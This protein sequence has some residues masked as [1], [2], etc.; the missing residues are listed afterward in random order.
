MT[1][2]K[3]VVCMGDS[4]TEGYGIAEEQKTYP[5][6]LQQILGKEYLVINKG[7]S[8]CCVTNTQKDGITIGL[9]YVQQEEY[10]EALQERGDIY[11][12]LLGTNDAQDGLDDVEDIQ[13]PYDNIIQY[14]N[15]FEQ[16]FQRILDD[17]Y[18][19]NSAAKIYVGIPAPVMECIW[20]KHQEKYLEELL[21]YYRNIRKKNPE[22]D[23][24]DIHTIFMAL[25]EE[26]CK[27]LYQEDNLHPNEEGAELI[28]LAVGAAI[29]ED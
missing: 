28:A 15:E 20:R 9:P 13:N 2:L 11:V 29:L 12:I 17:V 23:L 27:D 3:K 24:I 6:R 21:P 5:S 1:K 22:I 25:P 7:H 26:K 10:E 8:G 16:H 4:I 19:S 14:K 18:E